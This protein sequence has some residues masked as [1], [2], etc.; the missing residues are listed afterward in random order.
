[1]VFRKC[2]FLQLLKEKGE[3]TLK[4]SSAKDKQK[5]EEL[6]YYEYLLQEN[7]L[8]QDRNRYTQILE[9]FVDGRITIE[10]L[11]EQICEL[12]ISCL[13]SSKEL[14]NNLEKTVLTNFESDSITIN[15][16]Q[17]SRGFSDLLQDLSFELDLYD[18]NV[19]YEENLNFPDK[20]VFG[21][22]KEFFRLNVKEFFLPKMKEY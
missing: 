20:I 5:Y 9:D 8:W 16:N 14:V 17:K 4:N 2:R 11:D 7:I 10:E 3:L 21:M 6:E 12:R 19:S 1:M 22:S 18:P 13:K 15:Y